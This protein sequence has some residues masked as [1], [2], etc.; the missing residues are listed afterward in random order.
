MLES[1]VPRQNMLNITF[2]LELFFNAPLPLSARQI[3]LKYYQA[4]NETFQTK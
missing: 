1:Q 3:A 2:L 4:P